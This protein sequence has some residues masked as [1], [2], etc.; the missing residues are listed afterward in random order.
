[1]LSNAAPR[2]ARATLVTAKVAKAMVPHGWPAAPEARQVPGPGVVLGGTGEQDIP[3]L[4]TLARRPVSQPHCARL[5]VRPPVKAPGTARCF[6]TSPQIGNGATSLPRCCEATSRPCP[7]SGGA[8][9]GG[10]RRESA[11]H[12]W[13]AEPRR[14][15]CPSAATPERASSRR[16]SGPP[17]GRAGAP[18]GGVLSLVTFSGQAEKVTRAGRVATSD[19]SCVPERGTREQK[20][21]NEGFDTTRIPWRGIRERERAPRGRLKI[22]SAEPK[23]TSGTNKHAASTERAKHATPLRQIPHTDPRPRFLV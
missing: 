6:A 11:G 8:A 21:V 10:A 2:P 1:M 7:P 12:G 9:T 18:S 17:L 4:V 13:P 20:R 22:R 5:P 23:S 16:D 3:V 14:T 15:G 19:S